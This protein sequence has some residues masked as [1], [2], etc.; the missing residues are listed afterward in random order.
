MVGGTLFANSFILVLV[1]CSAVG[2]SLRFVEVLVS[3]G[4][5][6]MVGMEA[7]NG[8]IKNLGFS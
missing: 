4:G 3:E 1:L 6:R 8:A 5:C 7:F 2:D